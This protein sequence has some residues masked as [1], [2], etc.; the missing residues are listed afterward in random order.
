MELVRWLRI[1]A[2]RTLAV[3]L[4][5]IGALMLLLGWIGLSTKVFPAEQISYLAS[6][7][8]GGLFLLGTAAALWLSADLHDEWRVL[9]RADRHLEEI[10]G[11]WR[12]HGGP[13]VSGPGAPVSFTAVSLPSAELAGSER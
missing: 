2:D 12:A 13:P 1:Q 10:A 8:L 7:G 9:D 3:V 4:A 11:A 5:V 6:G